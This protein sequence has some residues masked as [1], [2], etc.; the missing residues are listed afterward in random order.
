MLEAMKASDILVF[1]SFY[2]TL[3]KQAFKA[4]HMSVTR[5]VVYKFHIN[6]ISQTGYE[7]EG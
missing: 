6:V 4:S 3:K 2:S 1:Q 5:S 7:R